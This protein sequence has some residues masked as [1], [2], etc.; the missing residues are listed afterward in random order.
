ME[1]SGEKAEE[2]SL[3]VF[4]LSNDEEIGNLCGERFVFSLCLV[5]IMKGG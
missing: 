4:L 1:L 5:L 2:D 3:V